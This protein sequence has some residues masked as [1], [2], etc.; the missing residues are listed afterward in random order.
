MVKAR[1][2]RQALVSPAARQD[3]ADILLWSVE[4]FGDEAAARYRT[5]L[6]QAIRDIEVDPDRLGSK[7]RPE[8]AKG[9]RTYHLAC[10]RDNVDGQRVKTPRH[11][12]LY[13]SGLTGLEI[14]R[15]LHDSR[16]LR[17]HL[18]SDY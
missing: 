2:G 15:I 18:P 9:A 11:F 12:I 4:K 6:I 10:S 7:C 17:R 16:G 14:A 8:L 3:I 5:L 1:V 13:R